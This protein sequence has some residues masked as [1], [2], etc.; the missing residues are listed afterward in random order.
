MPMVSKDKKKYVTK[1]KN[2][3][4]IKSLTYAIKGVQTV[5][6]E[7]RNFRF[8]VFALCMVIIGGLFFKVSIV[9]WLWLL[10]SATLVLTAE[11]I[12]SAIENVVDLATD[13]KPNKLAK[14]AKDMGAAAVLIIAIFATLV[15]AMIFL[16]RIYFWILVLCFAYCIYKKQ[17]RNMVML[18]PILGLWITA[19]AGPMSDLRY[20]YPM[21]LTAP[22]FI[23][24]IIR[25]CK[26]EKENENER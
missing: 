5:F 8:D 12:N 3:R 14:K 16:P 10:L 20:V 21:F 17:Y 4:F 22:I 24:I 15:A 11:I 25:D 2:R 7:E 6:N 18:L 23:G 9:E 13:L 26:I 19:I 1:W